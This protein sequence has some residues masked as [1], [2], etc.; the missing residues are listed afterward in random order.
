MLAITNDVIRMVNMNVLKTYKIWWMSLLFVFLIGASLVSAHAALLRTTPSDGEV[1]K[2]S[3]QK[4]TLAFS[5]HLEPDL[6]EVKLYDWN[7]REIDLAGPKITQGHASEMYAEVPTLKEGTYTVVWS[8]VSEDGHPV[9]GSYSFSVGKQGTGKTPVAD[10]H[11]IDVST[12]LLIVLRYMVEGMILF[13]G[14]GYWLAWYATKRHFPGWTEVTGKI[15]YAGW[16][17]LFVGSIAEWFVYSATLP[18][19]SLTLGLM[20][21]RW[22][23][24][25][26]SPFALVIIGQLV[27]SLLLVIPGMIRGWY[28][29]LWGV[30][31]IL[32]AFGGHVWGMSPT[33]AAIALRVLHLLTISVWLGGLL[34]LVLML[35]QERRTGQQMDKAVFRSFFVRI[36]MIAAGG[37][38]CTGIGMVVVQTDWASIMRNGNMTWSLL[39]LLKIIL[40]FVMLLLAL[41]QTLRW[42]KGGHL[43]SGTLVKVEWAVGIAI[44]LAGIWMSQMPYPLAVNHE[45]AKY[46]ETLQSGALQIRVEIASL[47][48]GT[49]KM[50]LLLHNTKKKEP[51]KVRVNL[52][53]EDMIIGIKQITVQKI[54]FGHY[55]AELPLTM[56]GKWK[57]TIDVEYEDGSHTTATDI[58]RI[59]EGGTYQ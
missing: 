30:L 35:R 40:F 7:A 50:N 46:A 15:R 14:G 47:Q 36:A 31:V 1:V 23:L 43:L 20:E 25:V 41:R 38:L 44:V 42:K 53:M 27:A 55:Q 16:G 58:I 13:G 22:N 33:W 2:S 59:S 26:Q 51:Q 29:F 21:G 10:N 56:T 37:A 8:V 45:A 6:I 17:L 48:P 18:G 19:N 34:Y 5:E 3:P 32:P 4:I 57:Y 11:F 12:I 24:L 39:L 28:L 52:E 9:K 49:Q 54:E